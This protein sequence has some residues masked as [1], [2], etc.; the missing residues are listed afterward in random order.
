MLAVLLST[1]NLTCCR[2]LGRYKSI[3]TD[4]LTFDLLQGFTSSSKGVEEL[5]KIP[6]TSG[7]VKTSLGCFYKDLT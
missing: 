2:G 7:D 3:T 6:Q 4:E 1:Q 5:L